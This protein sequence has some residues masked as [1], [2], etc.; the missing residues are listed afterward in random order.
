MLGKTRDNHLEVTLARLL[1]KVERI[2]GV[3]EHSRTDVLEIDPRFHELR[4]AVL[5]LEG[6]LTG[7][8]SKAEPGEKRP[9]TVGDRLFAVSRGVGLSTYGPTASHR[10]SL[11][12]ATA[13]MAGLRDE[14]ERYQAE[15]S[16]LV[17]ELIAAGAPWIE[18]EPLP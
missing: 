10:Q 8:R 7:L 2:G 12:I 6:R 4:G 3:I 15:L 1:T 16:D 13:E 17:R 9:P 11:E 5:E 18:G 14:L